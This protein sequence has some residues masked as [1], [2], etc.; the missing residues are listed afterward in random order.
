MLATLI[1]LLE[2][3]IYVLSVSALEKKVSHFVVNYPA[4]RRY[5]QH[6]CLALAQI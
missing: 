4:F 6:W 2:V 1:L 5:R 3:H